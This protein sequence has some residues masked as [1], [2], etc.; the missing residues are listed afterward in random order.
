MFNFVKIK[1]TMNM[2]E[3]QTTQTERKVGECGFIDV[4]Y[5]PQPVNDPN[6]HGLEF[7][8]YIPDAEVVA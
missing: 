3:M 1:N 7:A 2:E 4:H 8:E 6:S 5:N